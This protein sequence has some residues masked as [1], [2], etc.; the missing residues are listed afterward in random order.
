MGILTD[1]IGGGASGIGTLL[2]DAREAITGKKIVDP[3][4]LAK[5]DEQLAALQNG[6]TNGQLKINAAEAAS[7]NWFVA[8]WRPFVGWVCGATFAYHFVL[9]PVIKT[10]AYMWGSQHA[11]TELGLL[12]SFDLSTMMPVLLG[13]LGLGGMRSYEKKNGVQDSH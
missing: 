6:L 9:F 1:L 3:T 12:P 11:I 13:M 4:E 7:T 2:T 10:C 8:G 5:I